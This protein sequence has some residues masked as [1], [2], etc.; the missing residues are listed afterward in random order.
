M[1]KPKK[2]EGKQDYLKRCTAQVIEEGN[3][4][5]KA[6]AMC[7]AY[8]DKARNQ[9]SALNLT[10]ELNLAE[11]KD[12]DQAR[13]FLITAYTGAKIQS[14]FSNVVIDISGIQ[15]KEKMPI[16]REHARDRIVGH[17][18]AWK[19]DNF[20]ISGKF[21]NS[22]DDAKEVLAL[23]NEGYPWQ[24]SI[25]VRP[26]KIEQLED[27]KVSARVNGENMKGP[28]E[29][30]RESK[31]GEVSFV[32][33]GADDNTAAIT[34]SNEKF[35]VIIESNFSENTNDININKGGFKM[36]I[37]IEELKEKN[38]ELLA[39]IELA[40]EKAGIEKGIVQ[41]RDRVTQILSIE[42]DAKAAQKA[43]T[44]G[45]SLDASYKLFFESEKQKKTDALQD[46]ETQAPEGAGQDEPDI[47]GNT[48]KAPDIALAEKAIEL[49]NAEKISYSDALGKVMAENPDLKAAYEATYTI[50]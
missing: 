39:D 27:E 20:Y 2:N 22:T 10:S 34:M 32:S 38:P 8:W 33:L 30:W 26:M 9:R 44:E 49:M 41:E 11:F 17:G 1:P 43:I 18:D 36:P 16:L 19:E 7:N 13:E 48:S 4:S 47:K 42:G 31:V 3:D 29:I 15:T 12:G 50:Q 45:L 23:A 37:N 40:A 21:S 25:S 46:L 6:Y 24:A 14:W 5:K 35:D 28:L